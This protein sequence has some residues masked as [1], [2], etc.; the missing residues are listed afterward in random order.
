MTSSPN[1]TYLPEVDHLRA[2]AATLI[3]FYHGFQLF[4]S[5]LARGEPFNPSHWLSTMNPMFAVLIEGHTAVSMF[6]VLSGFIFTYGIFGNP[7]SYSGFIRNRI[8]RIYPLYL[9]LIFV[10]AYTH[11]NS[12][13][14]SGLVQ[15]ILPL[16]NLPGSLSGGSFASMFW[17]ISVEFQFYLIF[18][19]L[20][21]LFY[22]EG[23]RF[24]LLI[25]A[26]GIVFRV[27]AGLLGAN[28]RDLAYWTIVGRLD[29]FV[30][31]MLA[32]RIFLRSEAEGLRLRNWFPLALAGAVGLLFAF[33]RLGGWPVEALWK[34]VWPTAEGVAWALVI[35]T[36]LDVAKLLPVILS[37]SIAA[38]GARSYSIYLLHFM[39]IDLLIRHGGLLRLTG[40]EYVNALTTTVF[41]AFPL[42]LSLAGLTYAAIERPFLTLRKVYLQSNIER[43]RVLS[44]QT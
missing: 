37:R 31:G 28:V 38:V 4:G 10:A 29:Q 27:L 12:F 30:I 22:R 43:A 13:S 42:T 18:P 34:A 3:L 14:L 20:A 6:I 1:R 2:Y 17:T 11:Q 35:V 5:A 25:I 24:L 21:A 33:H 40:H 19:F 39:V 26:A 36:Y 9:F 23:S 15:V 8:L 32:A 7:I 41:L 44:E 16:A